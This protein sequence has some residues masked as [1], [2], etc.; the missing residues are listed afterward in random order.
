MDALV[1][2]CMFARGVEGVYLSLNL[3]TGH[4]VPLRVRLMRKK[5][6]GLSR[7]SWSSRGYRC[8]EKAWWKDLMV[9]RSVEV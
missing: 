4:Q 6:I 5:K 1:L 7:W 8:R 2:H 9:V 3:L